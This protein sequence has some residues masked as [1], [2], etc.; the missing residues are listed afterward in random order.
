MAAAL[1]QARPQ[2]S[3]ICRTFS[4]AWGKS[5]YIK[6]S[7]VGGGE[8]GADFGGK[9]NARR[10]DRS[11]HG[12]RGCFNFDAAPDAAADDASTHASM[13]AAAT[14]YALRTVPEQAV[15]NDDASR[16]QRRG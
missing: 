7:R 11:R 15:A 2:T 6:G 8:V 5:T 14:P 12:R 4:R 1:R 10:K 9:C 16:R 3:L 13:P